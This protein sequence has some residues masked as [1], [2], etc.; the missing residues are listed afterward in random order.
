MTQAGN[1]H[2]SSQKAAQINA[3]LN[4]T[5]CS[6]D[7]NR[8]K[9]LLISLIVGFIIM[10]YLFFVEGEIARIFG[11][12]LSPEWV[13]AWILIFIAY[14]TIMFF[15]VRFLLDKGRS[16][17]LALKITDTIMEA[18]FPSVL[19]FI[20]CLI[21]W[22]PIFLDTPLIFIYFIIIILSALRISALLS[23]L[24]GAVSALGYS[25]VTVWAV[26]IFDP[27]GNEL[28]LPIELYVV[29]GAFI[30]IAGLCSAYVARE[31]RS[32]MF[33]A[34]RLN[35][36]KNEVQQL[37][38]QQVSKEIAD[39]L[40]NDNAYSRKLEVSIMFLDIR[41]FSSFAEEREPEEVIAFQN[42]IFGPLLDIINSH[43]GIINQILGDGFM[44]T[45]GA[46]IEDTMHAN[47]ALQAGLRILERVKQLAD[48]GI[49]PV[50]R[51]G[52]GLHTG[53]VIVGNIGNENRK[54]YSVSGT[55]VI[56]AARLEQL[57]KQH[58]TQFL[59]SKEFKEKLSIDCQCKPVGKMVVKN[60]KQPVEVYNVA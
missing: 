10:G 18:A 51:V 44:A 50:T 53:E 7:L 30:L 1:N 13:V 55:P 38:G 12:E 24:G 47:N 2:I 8:I 31:I 29:R 39:T 26:N 25:L 28:N 16:I 19:I 15:G 4:Y 33:N 35:H 37:F 52:I 58:K 59:I 48:E 14:E 20:L 27:L 17:P 40:V 54:Q 57:N 42:N 43:H 9:L 45:F 34:Y 6:C 23:F 3:E 11:S 32:R 56:I 49:I 5:A 60:I 21:E 41:N 22:S 36:E 46:P